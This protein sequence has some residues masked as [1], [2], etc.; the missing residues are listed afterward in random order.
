MSG[1]SRVETAAAD[2]SKFSRFRYHPSEKVDLVVTCSFPELGKLTAL[3]FLEFVCMKPDAVVSLPTGKTPEYFIHWVQKILR[4]WDSEDIR[5]LCL[6]RGLTLSV[7]P[8]FDRIR[9]VQIDEFLPIN[10]SYANSYHAYIQ[11]FYVEGFG[12]P[13]KNCLLID[14][15]EIDDIDTLLDGVDLALRDRSFEGLSPYQIRMKEAIK[16]VDEYCMRYQAAIEELGGIDLFIGGIGPDGHIGFNIRGSAEESLTRVLNLNYESLASSAA[17]AL[18]GM[19]TAR[20][21]AVMTIGLATITYK[22]DCHTIILAAGEPKAE[23]I[24]AAVEAETDVLKYPSHALRKINTIFYITQGAAKLL[25][26]RGSIISCTR[27]EVRAKLRRGMECMHSLR[28]KKFLHTEPHH[29]DI[30]LGYLPFILATRDSKS[31][32]DIFACGSSGFNSVSNTFILSLLE[33]GIRRLETEPSSFRGTRDNDVAEFVQSTDRGRAAFTHR[34]LRDVSELW[35]ID[36]RD[37]L[38]D[39]LRELQSY[40]NSLY[41]GEKDVRLTMMKA[42]K[43]RCREFEAECLWGSLGWPSSAVKHLRLGFYTSDVFAPQP[44]FERDSLPILNM[45]LS[46]RPDV[47]TVALDPESA[48]PDTHYKV[49]QAVTAALVKYKQDTAEAPKVWGYRNVWC[50]FDLGEADIVLPVTREQIQSTCALFTKCFQTQATAEFPSYQFDG[51]FSTIVVDTWRKQ[52]SDVLTLIP[53]YAVESAVEGAIL[54]R[55]MTIDQLTHYS[56]SLS[57]AVEGN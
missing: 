36:S 42:L 2:G 45:L 38:V 16:R 17:E 24:K 9:F 56:R 28:D 3:R 22:P 50:R 19:T 26:A 14:T 35:E 44:V 27:D 10:P 11:R 33:D 34:F 40:I 4:E 57:K 6:S 23:V 55:E 25:S 46:L 49:L 7:P 20:K 5:Q 53:D 13:P 30:M 15:S 43:G 32:T 39:H 51:P 8:K 12:I 52:L 29:D 31:E 48:G 47:V 37:S 54:L 21:K 18:G 41:P 1:R